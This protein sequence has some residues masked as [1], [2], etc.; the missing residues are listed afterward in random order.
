M[1]QP[2]M[3]IAICAMLFLSPVTAQAEVGN[4]VCTVI[5]A[6]INFSGKTFIRL[7][8]NDGTFTNKFFEAPHPVTREMLAIALS[9]LSAGLDVKVRTDPGDPSRPTLWRIDVIESF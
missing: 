8:A 4:F 2:I 3:A 7:T 5:E 6:G 1:R 9:A